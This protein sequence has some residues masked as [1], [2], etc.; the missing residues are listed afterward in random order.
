MRMTE[1]L[2]AQLERL[3][4]E[5]VEY[6][7]DGFLFFNTPLTLLRAGVAMSMPKPTAL[8]QATRG[9]LKRRRRS[10]TARGAILKGK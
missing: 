4:H 1:G 10:A 2:E 8:C 7:L 9:N 3:S 5:I 6:V